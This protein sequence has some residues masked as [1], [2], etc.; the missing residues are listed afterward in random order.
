MEKDNKLLMQFRGFYNFTP[1][2]ILLHQNSMKSCKMKSF[3]LYIALMKLSR[4]TVNQKKI[5]NLIEHK[6]GK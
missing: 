3:I 2:Y 5:K 1:H 4:I 6:S